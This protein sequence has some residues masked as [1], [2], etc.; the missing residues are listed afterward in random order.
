MDGTQS[1]LLPP[2]GKT[3]TDVHSTPRAFFKELNRHWG[4][5]LDPCSNGENAVCKR[6][7][8]PEDDGLAQDWS[9]ERVFMNPPYTECYAWM[10]KAYES[11]LQGAIV[12]CLVPV[13]TDTAWWHEFA[14]RGE[15]HFIRGRLKFGAAT[16]NAPFPSAIVIFG[17]GTPGT[18]WS[19]DRDT[20]KSVREGDF[21]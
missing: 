1:V 3:A 7:F 9:Y 21:Q 11:S 12:L 5:T 15:I 13:R 17:R 16:A 14:M 18:T 19:M 10:Q 4:F 20:L 6:F 8:T 2:G